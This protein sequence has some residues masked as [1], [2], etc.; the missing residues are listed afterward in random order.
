[1]LEALGPVATEAF[2]DGCLVDLPQLTPCIYFLF[3]GLLV[4]TCICFFA[5]SA[6]ST[7]H[8]FQTIAKAALQCKF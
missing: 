5:N 2:A 4:L 7:T 6:P 3:I 8:V 1:M